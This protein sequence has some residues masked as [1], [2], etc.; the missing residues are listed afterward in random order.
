M[1]PGI[2]FL[3]F[4][5]LIIAP[6][7]IGIYIR[8]KMNEPQLV[9][10]K[11]V[12]ANLILF[13]PLIAL[14][15]IWGLSLAGDMV[16]L[17]VAGLAMT[18]AGLILGKLTAPFITPGLKARTTYLIG[19]AV[20][21][22]GFTMGG[23]VCYL[24]AGEKG[25]GLSAIFIS[26]FMP[27]MFI[28]IF[29]FAQSSSS[30][31]FSLRSAVSFFL[32]LQNL[33]LLAVIVA[34]MLHVFRIPRPVVFFP[35]DALLMISISLYYLTLGINFMFQDLFSIRK[36]YV[37]LS[38][39]KFLLLPLL[40]F[41]IVQFIDLNPDVRSVILIESFMPAA[42]YSVVV[43]ILFDLDSR[44]ASGMFVTSTVLFIFVVLPF[45]FLLKGI[46]FF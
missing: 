36:E 28:F 14:W 18:I 37:F 15:S 21:N 27:V 12:R 23:L 32:S 22:H 16:F 38:G 1:T 11:I 8:R 43:A 26:Y 7:L 24:M 9:A 4:Q 42:V 13:D 17:P 6:F 33:P 40:T 45:L 25:L 10:K 41:I 2:K 20:S 39:I 29:P 44:L 3:V 31:K 19:S 46:L 34:I 35:I 30:G 5:I